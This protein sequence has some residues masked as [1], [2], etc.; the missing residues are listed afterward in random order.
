MRDAI[1]FRTDPVDFRT[2]T[3]RIL[4]WLRH[5][6]VPLLDLRSTLSIHKVPCVSAINQL[7]LSASASR[8]CTCCVYG[9]RLEP[10]HNRIYIYIHLQYKTR[11]SVGRNLHAFIIFKLTLSVVIGRSPRAATN[12]HPPYRI[13]A[14]LYKVPAP[15]LS[16][17]SRIVLKAKFY[18][19]PGVHVSIKP[20]PW[21]TSL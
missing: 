4:Y 2:T 12:E 17:P 10:Q 13:F 1:S 6:S 9:V 20:F 8:S 14:G 18:F 21:N 3:S 19:S 11:L 16:R 15:P 5:I 7:S